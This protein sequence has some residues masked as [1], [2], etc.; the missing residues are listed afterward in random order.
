MHGE[1]DRQHVALLAGRV[2]ARRAVD[3]RRRRCR[4]RSRRRTARRPRRRAV[5][6][7]ADR[8]LAWRHG[9]LLRVKSA[10]LGRP[11][12][13][14]GRRSWG[15]GAAS[16][17]PAGHFDATYP[18]RLP[19][20]INMEHRRL[21]GSGFKVP[22]LSLG[23]GTFGGGNEFF[24][25]WGATDVAE[26]HAA[27]STS[28]SRPASTCSTRP[29]STRTALAEEILGQGDQGPARPGASSR[30]RPPSASA[31]GPTTSARRATT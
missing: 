11:R 8:V 29:T 20:E 22:V 26:A 16:S 4:G 2:V 6:P 12:A 30:P 31:P 28:A 23:T 3:G 21:G 27:S 13:P 15:G 25:A 1:L 18:R 19:K 17:P 10:V 5:V 9:C 24:K 7:E 14:R